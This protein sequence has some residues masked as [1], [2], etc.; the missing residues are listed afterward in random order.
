MGIVVYVPWVAA[1]LFPLEWRWPEGF[2]LNYGELLSVLPGMIITALLAPRVAYRRRDALM[3]LLPPWGFR[4]AWVIGTRLG[5]LPHRGWPER[6]DVFAVHGYHAAR[7]AVAANRYRNWRHCD[8]R[9]HVVS[10]LVEEVW[11]MSET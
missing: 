5:Q 4:I 11:L 7:I 10:E 9:S 1:R 3:L 2:S 8:T 6:T